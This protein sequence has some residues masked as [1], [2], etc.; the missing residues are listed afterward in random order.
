MEKQKQKLFDLLSYIEK[1]DV[2]V[3][4][5]FYFSMLLKEYYTPSPSSKLP[6]PPN[7]LPSSLRLYVP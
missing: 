6:S 2:P 1:S 4:S 3:T 5:L 7:K